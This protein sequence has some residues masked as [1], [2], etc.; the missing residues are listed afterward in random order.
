MSGSEADIA[1]SMTQFLLSR[2]LQSPRREKY[3]NKSLLYGLAKVPWKNS[4][5]QDEALKTFLGHT[6]SREQE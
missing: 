6:I 2:G 3:I 4:L 5:R 1:K